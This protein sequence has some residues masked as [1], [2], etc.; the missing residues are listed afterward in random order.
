MDVLAANFGSWDWKHLMALVVIAYLL[1]PMR[2]ILHRKLGWES[3]NDRMAKIA[4]DRIS[5]HEHSCEVATAK[6]LAELQA[7]NDNF[8]RLYDTVEAM[9]QNAVQ[10][11]RQY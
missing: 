2:T 9:R 1:S 7:L 5:Q 4:L 11:N 3:E 6:M 8:K 10:R